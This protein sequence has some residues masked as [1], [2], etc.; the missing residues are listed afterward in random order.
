[1]TEKWC[2]RCKEVK[3][4]D[5]FGNNRSRKDG[6]QLWCKS[7]RNEH[8]RNKWDDDE[9]YRNSFSERWYSD[10][11]YRARHQKH[12]QDWQKS[13]AGK[14]WLR[15]WLKSPRGQML[16]RIY[17]QERREW[18]QSTNDGSITPESL[19]EL[20][21]KQ[22]N[23]CYFPH[24][25][26]AMNDIANHP[27]QATIDHIEPRNK[28]GRNIISNIVWSCRS[29]NSSKNDKDLE[30]WLESKLNQET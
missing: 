6:K 27:D 1:M 25:K 23:L 8:Q 11:E 9:D 24:C 5:L 22:K 12:T 29:C 26:K 20:R 18:L 7:C 3:S 14:K 21:D 30:E 16:T 17:A 15:D 2:S 28:G 13:P 4:L 19:Q 10:A